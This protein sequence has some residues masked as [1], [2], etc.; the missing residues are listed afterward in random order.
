MVRKIVNDYAVFENVGGTRDIVFYYGA[1]GADSVT[2]V[3][4]AEADYIVGLLRNEK[5]MSYDHAL[6]R[7]STWTPEPVGESEHGA[8]LDAL[9]D[10]P[11]RDRRQHR[12]GRRRG[13]HAWSSWSAGWKAELR[14]AFDLARSRSSIS[15][16]DVPPNQATHGGRP[17]G[18]HHPRRR[19]RLGVLQGE[20]GAA[21][22]A[23]EIG[24]QLGWS[25][26]GYSADQL[27]PAVR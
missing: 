6:K 1:G 22:L 20:R 23:A 7:L 10:R 11:C 25:L 9:A 14:Q 12:L 19:R 24:Q 16:A 5:P 27:A 26:T 15:V 3:V 17:A 13:A 2:G 4:A 21:S 8:N 18:D